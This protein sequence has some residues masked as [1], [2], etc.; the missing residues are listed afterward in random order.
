[1]PSEPLCKLTVIKVVICGKTRFDQPTPTLAARFKGLRLL[2][3]VA[4]SVHLPCTNQVV[5]LRYRLLRVL[6]ST[7]IEIAVE[8]ASA[9]DDGSSAS[10]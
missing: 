3:A 6:S 5:Q 2:T 10:A 4:I 1:M 8:D 7:A 9:V